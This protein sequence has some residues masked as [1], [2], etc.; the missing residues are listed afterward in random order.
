MRGEQSGSKG[1]FLWG[2]PHAAT[3]SASSLDRR[4]A[5]TSTTIVEAMVDE[6]LDRADAVKRIA[7]FDVEELVE[8]SRED[9]SPSQK[10]YAHA[11]RSQ[12]KI[13]RARWTRSSR[14]RWLG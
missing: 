6:G 5:S 13:S 11:A 4:M 9:L 12:V 1:Y 7:M 8:T 3:G 2:V 14:R 10:R